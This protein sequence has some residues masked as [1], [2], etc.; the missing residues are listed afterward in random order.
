MRILIDTNVLIDFIV[1]RK[2]YD[3]DAV[4]LVDACDRGLLDGC[5]AAHSILDIFYILRKTVPVTE[6]R[7]TL[8]SLCEIFEVE[9]IDKDKLV[10][11]LATENFTDFEDCLQSLCATA[12]RADYIITRNLR[13]FKVGTIPAILPDSF[14]KRFF[15]G[16]NL[17]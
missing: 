4:K 1:M 7:E 2:P 8:R 15:D 5:I 14:C 13:D 11:A 12:F 6:R 3:A 10:R 9:G 16:D 17:R